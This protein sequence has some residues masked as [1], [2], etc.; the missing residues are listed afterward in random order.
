MYSSSYL[1]PLT[2]ACTNFNPQMVKYLLSEGYNASVDKSFKQHIY[3]KMEERCPSL[4][5]YVYQR[6]A[7][8]CMLKE[9]CR[10][11]IRRLL[12][13]ALEEKVSMLAL[14]K[15]LKDYILVDIIY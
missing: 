2:L 3:I 10:V 4:L 14:P 12:N 15:I 5:D 11:N 1:S 7:N 6:C 9:I 13:N 8:P